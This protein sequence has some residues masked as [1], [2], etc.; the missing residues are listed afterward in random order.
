FLSLAGSDAASLRLAW[1]VLLTMPGPPCLYYGDEIGMTGEHDP[2]CRGA[3]PWDPAAWDT[4][5]LATA[6]ALIAAR[7]AIPALRS[8]ELSPLGADGMAA[9]Y[10]RGTGPGEA[11]IVALN[12]GERSA[13]LETAAPDDATVVLPIPVPGLGEA[14]TQLADGRLRLLL[15]PRSGLILRSG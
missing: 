15:P 3:F 14:T 7:H 12:A 8:A 4:Q 13:V 5:L 9:A 2:A 10:R 11:V 6:R 1:L